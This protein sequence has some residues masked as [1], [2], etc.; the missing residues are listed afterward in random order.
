MYAGELLAKLKESGTGDNKIE[1]CQKE[2]N[3]KL[4]SAPVS[5]LIETLNRLGFNGTADKARR[6][7]DDQKVP[8]SAATAFDI[9]QKRIAELEEE[10]TKLKARIPKV[11]SGKG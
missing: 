4:E 10:N 9:A 5:V 3:G 7:C 6:M 2:L 1:A 8:Y 11:T